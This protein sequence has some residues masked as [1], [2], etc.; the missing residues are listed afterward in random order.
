MKS[1]TPYKINPK[2][3]VK[4]YNKLFILETAHIINCVGKFI[5]DSINGKDDIEKLINK[6]IKKYSVNEKK[7][8]NDVVNFL[9]TLEKE[10][11]IGFKHGK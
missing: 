5:L 7:A 4:E 9:S 8:R 1:K 2:M 11:L 10:G 3:V 6:V